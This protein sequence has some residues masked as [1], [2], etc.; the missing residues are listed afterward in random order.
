LKLIYKLIS[1]LVR[2]LKKKILKIK[3]ENFKAYILIKFK[4]GI[5]DKI[6]LSQLK[7]A[8][9]DHIPILKNAVRW[10]GKDRWIGGRVQGKPRPGRPITRFSTSNIEYIKYLL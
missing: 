8:V 3:P 7:T 10:M 6:I 9:L 5:K 4:L 2:A 1:I